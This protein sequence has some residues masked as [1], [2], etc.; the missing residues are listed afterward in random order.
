ME[1]SAAATS[2][3]RL[4]AS[5]RGALRQERTF[6]P[7]KE[8]SDEPPRLGVFICHCG[9]NI[10]G[11]ADI[12]TLAENA[13]TLP[14]V[15]YVQDNLFSCSQDSQNQMVEMIKEH[16]LNRVVVAACSPTTHAPMFQ[17]MLRDAG[18]N[19]YLFEMANIRNQC[20]WVHQAAP[21][22]ATEKCQD[23][24][25]MGVAKARLLRPLQYFTVPVNKRAL[26]IG[27]GMSGMT[28]ALAL[29]DQGFEVHLVERLDRLGGNARK[30]HTTWRDE[31]VQT[32]V[33]ALV[34]QVTKHEKI[35][36][37][38]W[39]IITEVSGSVGNFKSRLSTGP[40]IEHGIVVIAIGAV[41]LQAAPECLPFS[42]PGP[43]TD[44]DDPSG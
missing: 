11:V 25:R 15:E 30:L 22:M 16:N 23:L 34:D 21:D 13:R 29:A 28:S 1:G 33:D 26:V 20:T 38:Y 44:P 5:V 7:E 40:E 10:A 19:K 17:N 12:P 31:P 36:V 8:V 41:P 32:Y 2:S 27:G 37:H 4:L 39:S 6:P 35:T 3:A 43:G 42:R 14:Q 24:I 18:L 9:M